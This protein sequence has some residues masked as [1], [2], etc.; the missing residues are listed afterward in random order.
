MALG[1]GSVRNLIVWQSL[2]ITLIG[3]MMGLGLAVLAGRLLTNLLYGVAP[4]DK[5]TYAAIAL[6]LTTVSVVAS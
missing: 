6:L 3:L 5:A 4:I 2:R 1:A